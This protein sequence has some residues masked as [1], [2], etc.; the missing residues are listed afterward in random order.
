M[1]KF[2]IDYNMHDLMLSAVHGYHDKELLVY[3]ETVS[4]DIAGM[5]DIKANATYL[6]NIDYGLYGIIDREGNNGVAFNLG[7]AI[8]YVQGGE[9][10]RGIGIELVSP[11]PTLLQQRAITK[12]E[13]Y[14]L[15]NARKAQLD[16]LAKLSA[17][18]CRAHG[19]PVH[20]TDDCT[21]D[22]ITAHWNVSQKHSASQ[23]HTDC[24]PRHE[25]GYFP[26]LYVTAKTKRY[27]DEGWRF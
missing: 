1:P 20:Y 4:K 21:K 23:G 15:W 5:A 27:F 26:M 6:D 16:E 13:A 10:E 3:H 19:I 12:D 8:F 24:W 2:K 9:N 11:I 25:G 7:R 14:E 22:G 18:L 17:C